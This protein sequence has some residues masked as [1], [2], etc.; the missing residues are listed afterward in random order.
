MKKISKLLLVLASPLVLGLSSLSSCGAKEEEKPQEGEKVVYIVDTYINENNE[1]IVKYSDGRE[2]NRGKVKESTPSTPGEETKKGT[3]KLNYNNAEGKVNANNLNREVGAT[4]ILTITPNEN[5]L[6]K[7]VKLNGSPLPSPYIF[8]LVEGENVVDV[9]FQEKPEV[10]IIDPEKE[11][12]TVIYLNYDGTELYRVVV[13]EGMNAVYIGADP[14]KPSND[15]NDFVFDGWDNSDENITKNTTLT[16]TFHAIPRKYK[17]TFLNYD[18]SV[19]YSADFE[20]GSIPSFAGENPTRPATN[21][22]TY[23]FYG[24]DK[25]FSEVKGAQTYK[26]VFTENYAPTFRNKGF[27]FEIQDQNKSFVVKNYYGTDKN[28]IIPMEFE[29]RPVVGIKDGAFDGNTEITSIYIPSTIAKIGN[30]VFRG[31]EKLER[32]IV[33]Q[34]NPYF[35][36]KDGYKLIYNE[37]ELIYVIS[38]FDGLLDLT[39]DGLTSIRDGALNNNK[40]KSLVLSGY[41]FNTIAKLFGGEEYISKTMHSIVIDGGNLADNAFKNCSY[42]QTISLLENNSN[43]IQRIGNHAFDGCSS[44]RELYI[45]DQTTELGDYCF[46]NMTSLA[47]L[48]LGKKENNLSKMGLGLF[49]NCPNLNGSYMSG[50]Y[51][52]GNDVHNSIALIKAEK[53][54][55]IY[56]SSDCKYIAENAFVGNTAIK[57]IDCDGY[58]TGSSLIT[59]DNNAFVGATNLDTLSYVPSALQL[60]GNDAFA[61]TKLAT[62]KYLTNQYDVPFYINALSGIEELGKITKD[63]K[64]ISSSVANEFASISLSNRKAP[65]IDE[66]NTVFEISNQ[67]LINKATDTLVYCFDQGYTTD[68]DGNKERHPITVHTS[69]I[70]NNAFSYQ[71][72]IQEIYALNVVEV[73]ARAFFETA[74]LNV[75]RFGGSLK[76]IGNRAFAY[77]EYHSKNTKF[78]IPKNIET[79][80]NPDMFNNR[81]Y[82]QIYTDFATLEDAE[83]VWGAGIAKHVIPGQNIFSY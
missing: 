79:P 13:N 49:S 68:S 48:Q 80:L 3:V 57:T 69:K 23:A 10:P 59:I 6:I 66:N 52:L 33:N 58:S 26:A 27:V 4:I 75:L 21:T 45:N 25:P 72:E 20:Y 56:L 31:T 18:D 53:S 30:N 24:W 77:Y 61:G 5:F 36:I 41:L 7:D 28:V 40:L 46:A 32:I 11:T 76:K 39:T 42:V 22:T 82:Y 70:G 17:V 78:Y 65:K 71:T 51:Y 15:M 44:I 63:I 83:A 16:A 9:T 43:P 8:T 55:N 37:S 34:E 73:G 19:I 50:S 47:N 60:I 12:F 2:E 35:K 29:G 67:Q 1:L 14:V 81:S 74:N 54:A 62:K 64:G 38:S